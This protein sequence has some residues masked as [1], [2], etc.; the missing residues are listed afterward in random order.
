[1]ETH[2][3]EMVSHDCC[4]PAE[5]LDVLRVNVTA[6]VSRDADK[7]SGVTSPDARVAKPK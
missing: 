2:L 3:A 1:M 6:L 5:I 4:E 7:R